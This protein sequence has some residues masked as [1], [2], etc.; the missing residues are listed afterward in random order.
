M[1]PS[2][3]LVRPGGRVT[4]N[5]VGPPMSSMED[6]VGLYRSKEQDS[7]RAIVFK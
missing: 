6:E 1:T 7:A 2:V 5:L 4:V 3:D